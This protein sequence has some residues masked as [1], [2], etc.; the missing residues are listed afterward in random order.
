MKSK[1]LMGS[2]AVVAS[3]AILPTLSWGADEGP[4][5][6]KSKCSGCHGAGGEGKPAVKAPA[7]K[8]TAK[9]AEQITDHLLKGEPTSKPPHSK[10][11]SGLNEDQ[12]KAIA[13]FVK[14]LK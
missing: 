9:T 5:L 4:A 12:A 2:A 11:M 14:T 3:L 8:G 10:G 7:L 6:Y 1:L 13:D